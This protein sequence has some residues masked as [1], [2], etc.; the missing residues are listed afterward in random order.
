MSVIRVA[1]NLRK[2][3]EDAESNV[4]GEGAF[5][6]FMKEVG[7]QKVKNPDTGNMVKVK[8]L[9]GPKGKA[10]VQKEFEKWKGDSNKKETG[11][12]GK[13]EEPSLDDLII[14]IN[15]PEAVEEVKRDY[16]EVVKERKDDLK[17]RF[18]KMRFVNRAEEQRDTL[19]DTAKRALDK[20]KQGDNDFEAEKE[21]DDFFKGLYEMSRKWPGKEN[22]KSTRRSMGIRLE[23]YMDSRD[24]LKAAKVI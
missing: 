19:S 1:R 13:E 17:I 11:D 4:S 7:D 3:A 14:D 2:L 5:S 24:A 22:L 18:R 10:L 16:D 6:D 9:K 12:A 21:L 8:S 15:D 23:T 20:I